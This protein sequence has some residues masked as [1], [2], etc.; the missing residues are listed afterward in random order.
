MGGSARRSR[1][2]RERGDDVSTTASL[3]D[4]SSEFPVLRREIKG[5]R[6]V[7]LDSGATSQTPQPV[8]DAMTHYYTHSRAS[9]H[10]GVYTLAVEATDL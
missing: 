9:I 8:I 6:L 1:R 4:L 2:R 3:P 5:R 7:Y 10:R